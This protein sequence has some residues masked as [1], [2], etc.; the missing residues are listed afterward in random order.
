MTHPRTA[1]L[2]V[3]GLE[4]APR[5]LCYLFDEADTMR[6]AIKAITCLVQ[7]TSLPHSCMPFKQSF[8]GE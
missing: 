3:N 2:T 8:H 7:G 4:Y 5:A 1:A 6:Q